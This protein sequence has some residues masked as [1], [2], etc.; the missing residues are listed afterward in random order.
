MRRMTEKEE[1]LTKN[2]LRLCRPHQDMTERQEP[3][4]LC[5]LESMALRKAKTSKNG[6]VQGAAAANQSQE[7]FVKK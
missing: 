2:G 4:L 1:D 6:H 3:L 5:L 7:L